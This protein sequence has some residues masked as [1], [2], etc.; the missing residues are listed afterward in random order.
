MHRIGRFIVL[1]SAMACASSSSTKLS[2][3]WREPNTPQLAFN[4]ML[5]VYMSP[6][7]AARRPV[8][9]RLASRIPNGVA[10]YQAVPDLSHTDPRAAR[11]Q[12]QGKG[13]DGVVAMR[14]VGVEQIDANGSGNNWYATKRDFDAFWGPSWVVVQDPGYRVD[15]RVVTV[16]TR[17]FSLADNRLVWAGRTQTKNPKSVDKL[18]ESTV[19]AVASSLREQGLIR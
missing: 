6:D 4:R 17:I 10:A 3:S 13:F 11:Q 14:V 18:V 16:E 2:D 8:E 19:D 1:A 5:A 7:E 15:N 9:D 12:L